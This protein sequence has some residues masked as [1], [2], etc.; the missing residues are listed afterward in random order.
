MFVDSASIN[1]PSKSKIA[2]CTDGVA[3]NLHRGE[4]KR[5]LTLRE[6]HAAAAG[7]DGAGPLRG[8][9][10]LAAIA[11][12]A[13]RAARVQLAVGFVS[14]MF[15]FRASYCRG[16][17]ACIAGCGRAWRGPGSR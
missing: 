12:I 3:P 8:I 16:A 5:D 13:N 2:V 4:Q 15:A 6:V 17:D 1:R 9:K 14:I 11:V 7:D 10:R